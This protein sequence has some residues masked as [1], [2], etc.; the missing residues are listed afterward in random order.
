MDTWKSLYSNIT[1]EPFQSLMNIGWPGAVSRLPL[2][3]QEL[4]GLLMR[5]NLGDKR[6]ADDLSKITSHA[7]H[8]PGA[9]PTP[10]AAR[11]IPRGK[12]GEQYGGGVGS[13]SGDPRIPMQ[14]SG[15][16]F[17]RDG[18]V[19][20]HRGETIMPARMAPLAP[21]GG[22]EL[23][24]YIDGEKV[25]HVVTARQIRRARYGG[26]GIPGAVR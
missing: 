15:G 22:Q 10:M 6:A 13:V 7:V 4:G 19:Y 9:A 2:G 8:A 14:A 17:L 16:L 18:L 24:I 26:P 11:F 12:G 1:W 20:G 5:A 25:E 3:G 21:G 23:H